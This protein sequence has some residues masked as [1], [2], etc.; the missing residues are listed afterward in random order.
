MSGQW[1]E[2]EVTR[3]HLKSVIAQVRKKSGAHEILGLV[4]NDGTPLKSVEVQVT[5]ASTNTHYS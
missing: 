4:L 3:T 2:T 5:L 1:V